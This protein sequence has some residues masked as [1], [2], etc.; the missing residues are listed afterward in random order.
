MTSGG[1]NRVKGIVREVKFESYREGGVNEYE[2]KLATQATYGNLV[3]ERGL[4]RRL[5]NWHR[6]VSEGGRSARL[7][8]SCCRT[9]PDEELGAG[10]SMA[11]C[12]SS[13]LV[14]LDAQRAR[15]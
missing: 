6:D 13:G 2:H 1:F 10:M 11:P 5:W 12:R 7:S 8:A 4:G 14:D 9:R 3:L 15:C